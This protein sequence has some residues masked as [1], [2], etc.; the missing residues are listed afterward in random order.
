MN[1][2]TDRQAVLSHFHYGLSS[3]L[4]VI[5]I[6]VSHGHFQLQLSPIR[7]GILDRHWILPAS[8]SKKAIMNDKFDRNRKCALWHPFKP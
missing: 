4:C 3:T 5:C 2:G 8:C 7:I 1:G 6:P